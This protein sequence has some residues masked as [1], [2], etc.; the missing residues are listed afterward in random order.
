[1]ISK[2]TYSE[3]LIH[4]KSD[5]FRYTNKVNIMVFLKHILRNRSFKYSFWFRIANMNNF[6]VSSIAKVIHERLSKKYGLHIP[7]RTKIGKGLYI[8]HSMSIVIHPSTIIG[9]NCNL[10]Q[11]VTIGSNKEQA[12]IIGDNVYIGPSVCI[13]EN[14]EIGNNVTIGAGSVVTKNI[15]ENS[16]AAGVPAKVISIKEPGRFIMNKWI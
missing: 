6:F 12:A 13:I 14:V 4:I 8:G 2:L 7:Y 1:M 5:L 9:N 3:A 16:T 11:F 15:E 10:S